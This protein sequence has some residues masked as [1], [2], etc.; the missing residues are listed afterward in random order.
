M[1]QLEEAVASLQGRLLDVKAELNDTRSEED[2]NT[3][4]NDET[5]E[6]VLEESLYTDEETL[7]KAKPTTPKF[8]GEFSYEALEYWA[9]KGRSDRETLSENSITNKHTTKHGRYESKPTKLKCDSCDYECK[10]HTTMKK[11]LNSKHG[12]N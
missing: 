10:K 5:Y 6:R 9:N 11:H 1:K 8:T 12:G 3:T 2:N 7:N 4:V